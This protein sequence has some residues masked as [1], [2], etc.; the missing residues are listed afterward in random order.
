MDRATRRRAYIAARKAEKRAQPR[1]RSPLR[2]MPRIFIPGYV[3]NRVVQAGIYP[4]TMA[5]PE[6]YERLLPRYERLCDKTCLSLA[7]RAER[8]ALRWLLEER[9]SAPEATEHCA[10][11]VA[12]SPISALLPSDLPPEIRK[13]FLEDYGIG[14]A[15]CHGPAQDRHSPTSAAASSAVSVQGV[16]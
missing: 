14:E 9:D 6:L 1:P 15:E 12:A 2:D 13:Q 16:R 7:Q 11:D 3:I 5:A 4:L 10:H 8:A